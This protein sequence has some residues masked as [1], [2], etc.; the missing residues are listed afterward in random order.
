[1]DFVNAHCG[2]EDVV[3][4]LTWKRIILLFNAFLN[5][6]F[7]WLPCFCILEKKSS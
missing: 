4:I 5:I 3:N 6:A 1:M 2:S 7:L